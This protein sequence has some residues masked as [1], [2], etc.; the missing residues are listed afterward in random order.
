RDFIVSDGKESRTISYFDNSQTIKSN[1]STAAT[2][3]KAQVSTVNVSGTVEE[4]DI[5]T[6]T[7]SGQTFNYTATSADVAVGQNAAKNVAT[8]LQASISTAISSG[9]LQAI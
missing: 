4:G 8:R 7:V 5:F 3:T 1:L 9:R 2:S 6:V